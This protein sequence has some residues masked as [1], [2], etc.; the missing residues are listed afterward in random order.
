MPEVQ[1]H[2]KQHPEHADWAFSVIEITRMKAFLIDGKKPALPKD[3]GIGLWLAP[4]DP[5]Q[6]ATEIGKDVFDTI[7]TPSQDAGLTLGIWIP[8]HEYVAYMQE[9]GHYA[10]YGSVTLVKESTG[11][12]RGEIQLD[13]LHVQSSA[14]P[15]G[16]PQEDATAGTQVLFAPGDTVANAVVLAGSHARHQAC[17]AEWSKTGDHPL[18]RGVF[19]GPTYMTTYGVP[20]KGRLYRLRR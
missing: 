12:F 18:A 14:T 6:L 3:S 17:T 7:I 19:V 20:L 9:R 16:D 15:H 13:N 4:V 11:V 2:L 8:D 1:E 10:E 5:S